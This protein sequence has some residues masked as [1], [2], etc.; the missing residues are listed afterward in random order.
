MKERK[1]KSNFR[2]IAEAYFKQSVF[3]RKA[4]ISFNPLEFR[5]GYRMRLLERCWQLDYEIEKCRLRLENGWQK[6]NLESASAA[7]LQP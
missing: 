1:Y 7:V 2:I 4:P 6:A 3:D 5:K